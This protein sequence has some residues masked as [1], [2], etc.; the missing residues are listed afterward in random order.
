MSSCGKKVA[1]IKSERLNYLKS[2][3]IMF[4]NDM[5]LEIDEIFAL[6]DN[7]KLTKQYERKKLNV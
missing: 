1:K 3:F 4:S 7:A 5:W 6:D 2:S